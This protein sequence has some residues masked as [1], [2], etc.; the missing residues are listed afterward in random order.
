MY[1]DLTK[2][3]RAKRERWETQQFS[4]LIKRN[5][6][7]RNSALF[8]HILETGLSTDSLLHL[9]ADNSRWKPGCAFH[10][11]GVLSNGR[12]LGLRVPDGPLS[13][14]VDGCPR[15]LC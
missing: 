1:L 14:L 15:C 13:M 11:L 2:G 6:S 8:Y 5:I 9:S 12:A 3:E 4:D 7:I 10:P